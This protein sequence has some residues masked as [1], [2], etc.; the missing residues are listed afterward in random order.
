MHKSLQQ[1]L[2]E[3]PT[4]SPLEKAPILHHPSITVSPGLDTEQ[5]ALSDHH[6]SY[7]S[8]HFIG[9]NPF[10]SY[11][12][13]TSHS[14][15]L[16]EDWVNKTLQDTPSSTL[17]KALE[18]VPPLTQPSSPTTLLLGKRKRSLSPPNQE[19]QGAE[20]LPLTRRLLDLHTGNMTSD[21]V[22]ETPT[23]ETVLRIDYGPPRSDFV[24]SG[25]HRELGVVMARMEY[26]HIYRNSD[27]FHRH[28]YSEFKE[29]VLS[30]IIPEHALD[31]EPRENSRFKEIHR[32]CA[33][34]GVTKAI[35]KRSMLK[36]IVKDDIQVLARPGDESRNL[37]EGGIFC[38]D[39]EPLR[40]GLLP[41][42]YPADK[43][44]AEDLANRLRT[45][46]MGVC[47]NQ[48]T[49]GCA[50]VVNAMRSLLHMLGRE[51]TIGPDKD[52]YIYCA[53]LGEDY[54]EWWVGWAEECEGGWV[55]WHMNSLRRESFD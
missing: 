5:A 15:S 25:L 3:P 42:N 1:R 8:N 32:I 40:E 31:A 54:M 50:T 43:L 7:T 13:S 20:I 16:I 24:S 48:A 45:D 6:T 28:D 39:E 22:Q 49:R 37:F 21:S 36:Y 51:D 41:H 2:Y 35:F 30:G 55:N 34:K 33:S 4:I 18:R 14:A 26:H 44:S 23:E 29:H 19:P 12:T 46:G 17:A 38:Q 11:E 47:R 10:A 9:P 52:T 27:A 53:T